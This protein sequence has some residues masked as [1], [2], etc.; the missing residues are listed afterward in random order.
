ICIQLLDNSI[1]FYPIKLKLK[2]KVDCVSFM[3]R[4]YELNGVKFFFFYF[5]IESNFCNEIKELLCMK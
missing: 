2:A 3:K 5:L 4:C 1:S